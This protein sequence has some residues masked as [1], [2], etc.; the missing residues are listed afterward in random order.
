MKAFKN[1]GEDLINEV[2]EDANEK[3]ISMCNAIVRNC[4]ANSTIM[5]VLTNRQKIRTAVEKDVFEVVKGWGMWIETIEITDVKILSTDLF[6][7]LQ[8]KFREEQKQSAEMNRLTIDNLIETEKLKSSIEMNEKR[9]EASRD[10]T[11]YKANKDLELQQANS[12]I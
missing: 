2:P 8:T 12:K 3:L 6:K 9:Q 1:L 7:D 4:I 10:Q 5:E 11:V